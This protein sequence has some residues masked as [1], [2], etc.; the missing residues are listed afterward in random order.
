MCGIVGYVG[1]QNAYPV[2]IKVPKQWNCQGSN[3]AGVALVD[4]GR[5]LNCYQIKEKVSD[6]D[7]SIFLKFILLIPKFAYLFFFFFRKFN[8]NGIS[9]F[10]SSFLHFFLFV[11]AFFF[12][13]LLLLQRIQILKFF[14]T[15]IIYI[16][17]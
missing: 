16:R 15:S 3:S 11:T 13:L 8:S 5:R 4:Q 7:I 14:F 6:L 10:L 1:K 9:F 17:Y 12:N 2:L